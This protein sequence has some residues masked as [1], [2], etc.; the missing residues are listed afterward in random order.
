MSLFE[1]PVYSLQMKKRGDS[2]GKVS[3]KICSNGE[4]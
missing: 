4:E 1:L 2:D 3:L